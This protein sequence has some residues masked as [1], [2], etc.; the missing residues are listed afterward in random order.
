MILDLRLIRI[1]ETY[2]REGN[3]PNC[4]N[5]A[6]E[7]AATHLLI[8]LIELVLS[9]QQL[10]DQGANRARGAATLLGGAPAGACD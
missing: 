5:L 4:V 1:V 8:R 9:I 6:A 3:V 2:Q 7:T 10:D